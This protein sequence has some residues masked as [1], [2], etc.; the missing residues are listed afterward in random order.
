MS[1]SGQMWLMEASRMVIIE[2]KPRSVLRNCSKPSTAQCARVMGTAVGLAMTQETS[3]VPPTNTAHKA[4]HQMVTW[5]RHACPQPVIEELR[6]KPF[7]SS[8][9]HCQEDNPRPPQKFDTFNLIFFFK[10]L[11]YSSLERGL[12]VVIPSS[13]WTKVAFFS[14]IFRG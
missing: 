14:Q 3:W 13:W 6:V 11:F 1:H 8:P 12:F 9:T 10:N 2:A 5:H 7:N 4:P